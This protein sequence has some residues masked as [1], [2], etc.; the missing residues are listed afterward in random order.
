M[1]TKCLISTVEL[2]F[3]HVFL[4]LSFLSISKVVASSHMLLFPNPSP[5]HQTV[6]SHRSFRCYATLPALDLCSFIW[7]VYRWLPVCFKICGL[8][9]FLQSFKTLVN[10]WLH[11]KSMWPMGLKDNDAFWKLFWKFS[12]Y[13]NA[14]APPNTNHG[15]PQ[16]N[17]QTEWDRR[18]IQWW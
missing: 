18:F 5:I 4:C 7:R 1:W 9:F 3:I 16:L 11:L 6:I 17:P 15:W 2:W 12:H 13:S 8:R 10:Y 14:V